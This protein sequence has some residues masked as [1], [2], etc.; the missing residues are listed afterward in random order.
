MKSIRG[1]KIKVMDMKNELRNNGENLEAE[2]SINSK[3]QKLIFHPHE[4]LV[5]L[6]YPINVRIHTI[7]SVE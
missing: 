1:K 4:I 2:K 3:L 6:H 5:L 7:I